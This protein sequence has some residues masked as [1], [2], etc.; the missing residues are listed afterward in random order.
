MQN[1]CDFSKPKDRIRS[2]CFHSKLP[3]H[4]SENNYEDGKMKKRLGEREM[5]SVRNTKCQHQK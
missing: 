5:F 4:T 3:F 1:Q 2:H